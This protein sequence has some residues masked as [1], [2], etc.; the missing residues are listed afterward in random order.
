MEQG[1][2][3]GEMR[4]IGN[5]K[6]CVTCRQTK[7]LEEFNKDSRTSDGLDCRCRECSR[8]KSKKYRETHPE[9]CDAASKRWREENAEHVK[10]RQKAYREKNREELNAKK[11]IYRQNNPDKIKAYAE[12]HKE[13]AKAWRQEHREE[14]TE[15]HKE[16]RN[17]NGEKIRNYYQN[18]RK[19]DDQ[20]RLSANYRRRISLI[21]RSG[22]ISKRMQ[23]LLGCDFE[24]LKAHIEKQF[25][26][27][28]TWDN[29]GTEGWQVDHIKPCAAFD[30]TNPQQVA[31]CFNYK[32]MQPLWRWENQEKSD[33]LQ[34]GTLGRRTWQSK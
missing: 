14:L 19:A 3:E 18:K 16:W 5:L 21:L 24:T 26:P 8:V 6:T 28:M 1:R 30:M 25:K 11:R 27:G 12:A 4:A 29:Y 22:Q 20:Y 31:E 2:K 23:N 15:Y 9:T 7:P 10:A 34:N 13:E 33:K 32:N 17:K